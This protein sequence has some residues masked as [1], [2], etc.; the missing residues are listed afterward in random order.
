MCQAVA[1]AAALTVPTALR[2]VVVLQ[3]SYTR[4]LCK[5]SHKELA[6]CHQHSTSA[7]A[8]QYGNQLLTMTTRT[9][10]S[11]PISPQ[12][13]HARGNA[14]TCIPKDNCASHKWLY[15]NV[16]TSHVYNA[17]NASQSCSSCLGSCHGHM[18]TTSRTFSIM[19]CAWLPLSADTLLLRQLLQLPSFLRPPGEQQQASY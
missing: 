16:S 8:L 15:Y 2:M 7:A 10:D 9:A 3:H 12:T 6:S 19:Y 5:H 1:A 11:A 17:N 13:M 4:A 18:S 14:Q